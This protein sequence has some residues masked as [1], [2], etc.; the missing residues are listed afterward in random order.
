MQEDVDGDG[1]G[2]VCD[3]C[4]DVP[5]VDQADSDGD[6]EGDACNARPRFR[7]SNDPTDLPNFSTIQAAVDAV[8]SEGTRIEVLAGVGP[9]NENVT[10]D[11]NLA[12]TIE[13]SPED[14]TVQVIGQSAPTFRLRSTSGLAPLVLRGLTVLDGTTGVEVTADSVV[15]QDMKII[16]SESSAIE[17]RAGRVS[18]FDT[19]FDAASSGAADVEIGTGATLLLERARLIGGSEA[20][21]IASGDVVARSTVVLDAIVGVRV[22]AGGSVSLDGVTVLNAQDFGV[23][24]ELGGDATVDHGV[25]ANSG[26]ADLSGLVCDALSWSLVSDQDCSA[27]NDNVF[28]DP[29]LQA[30]GS[31][32][33]ASTIIDLGEAVSAADLVP[34]LDVDRRPRLLDGDLDGRVFRDLGP[35]S[36]SAHAV[37]RRSGI[38]SSTR[39]VSW[40]GP[41]SRAR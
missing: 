20:G 28:G 14:E 36:C 12:M 21:L 3:V 41:P 11:R 33:E 5:D 38:W 23:L 13:R 22:L 8:T 39:T 17:V 1:L 2:D 9:Y 25:I 40:S 35:S 6:G 10:V 37:S 27:S 24:V 16:D 29:M 26:V 7:V 19:L 34:C 31:P 4:P 30:D 15:L 18:A 32:T